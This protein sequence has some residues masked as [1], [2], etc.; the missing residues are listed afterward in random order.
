MKWD[1]Q[2]SDIAPPMG[3]PKKY[4]FLFGRKLSIT[5]KQA[6]LL[7]PTP[8]RLQCVLPHLLSILIQV[9]QRIKLERIL[10]IYIYVVYFIL[11]LWDLRALRIR[12]QY[13]VRGESSAKF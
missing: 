10:Y 12:D 9:E 1:V 13:W 8:A 2:A 5:W 7:L 11:H 4:K 3:K 6:T